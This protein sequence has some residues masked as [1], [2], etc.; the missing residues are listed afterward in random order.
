MWAGAAGQFAEAATRSERVHLSEALAF[1]I[2]LGRNQSFLGLR[3]VIPRASALP[4]DEIGDTWEVR[5]DDKKLE[6]LC[7]GER[8]MRGKRVDI[9]DKLPLRVKALEAAATAGVLSTHDPLGYW[10][11]LGAD[12][13]R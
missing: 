3:A 12:L 11:Q 13:E 9:A 6:M 1:A 5:F 8:Q 2:R 4:C 10:H 7:T